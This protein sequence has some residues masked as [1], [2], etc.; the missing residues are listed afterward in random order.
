MK[1]VSK[2]FCIVTGIIDIIITLVMVVFIILLATT[3]V[4]FMKYGDGST[5]L[6]ESYFFIIPVSIGLLIAL[7]AAILA[8]VASSGKKGPLIATIVFG[9]MDWNIFGILGGIFGLIGHRNKE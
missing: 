7:V 2:A 9:F 6:S 3:S 5:G 4:P 1:G 8:F